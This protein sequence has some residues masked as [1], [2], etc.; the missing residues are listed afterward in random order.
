MHRYIH[1]HI[2]EQWEITR[3]NEKLLEFVFLWRKRWWLLLFNLYNFLNGVRIT[4]KSIYSITTQKCV[5]LC[6]YWIFCLVFMEIYILTYLLFNFYFKNLYFPKKR[7]SG[8]QGKWEN[9]NS[10]WEPHREFQP[11]Y[12]VCMKKM[13]EFKYLS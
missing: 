3:N 13:M 12:M 2:P 9:W 11:R 8:Q 4:G 7:S 6:I 10:V 5:T 1:A